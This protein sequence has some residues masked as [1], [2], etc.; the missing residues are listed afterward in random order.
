[1]TEEKTVKKEF[2]KEER[3]KVEKELKVYEQHQI[4]KI[5]G[6]LFLL[7]I[8]TGVLLPLGILLFV[9]FAIYLVMREY[10]KQSLRRELRD[11]K[12]K[13]MDSV[14]KTVPVKEP[15]VEKAKQPV[16]KTEDS[17]LEVLKKRYAK[18]KIT[19]KQFEEMKRDIE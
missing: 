10:K 2:L 16:T 14:T 17:A 11:L 4:T 3:E 15:V 8:I 12:L 1:M 6:G 9:L 19:K 7:L 18:G 5:I 13:E